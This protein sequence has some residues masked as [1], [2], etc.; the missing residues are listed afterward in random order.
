MVQCSVASQRI[1][2]MLRCYN[3][4]YSDWLSQCWTTYNT[5][6]VAVR[7]ANYRSVGRWTW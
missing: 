7:T 1:S 5:C 2:D 4:V 3:S 6:V